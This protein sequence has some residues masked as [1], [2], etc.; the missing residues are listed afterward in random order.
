MKSL[1]CFFFISFLIRF[2]QIPQTLCYLIQSGQIKTPPSSSLV[3]IQPHISWI[4][5]DLLL[6]S[7]CIQTFL[8]RHTSWWWLE[9][10]T[11]RSQVRE[12]QTHISKYS[13]LPFK[14]LWTVGFFF[15]VSSTT[16]LNIDDDKKR[17]FL[18]GHVTLNTGIIMRIIQ[19]C[20][21]ITINYI[22]KNI[23]K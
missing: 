8:H 4:R 16:I 12:Q 1:C 17:L 3:S 14:S 2:S 20:H 10:W 6:T 15:S 7:L 23:L 5:Y 9:W 21:R 19:F 22:F 13:T 18:K 11:A